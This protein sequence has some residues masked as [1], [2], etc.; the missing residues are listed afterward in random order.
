MV[1]RLGLL[2]T[3]VGVGV[4]RLIRGAGGPGTIGT[5]DV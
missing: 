1:S 2:L 4:I 5:T 3:A